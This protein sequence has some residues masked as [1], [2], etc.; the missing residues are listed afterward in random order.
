MVFEGFANGLLPVRAGSGDGPFDLRHIRIGCSAAHG[1]GK[2]VLS[3][4]AACGPFKTAGATRDRE[5]ADRFGR[6]PWSDMSLQSQEKHV[7][8]VC[9]QR[10]S[11]SCSP[12]SHIDHKIHG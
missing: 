10:S 5:V 6:F 1:E 8:I 7:P 9:G 4:E 3:G 2:L 11:S 12:N